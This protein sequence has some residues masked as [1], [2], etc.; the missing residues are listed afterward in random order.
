MHTDMQVEVHFA[1]DMLHRKMKFAA[2][3]SF[4]TFF[5]LLTTQFLFQIVILQ[6]QVYNFMW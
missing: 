1:Y 5:L 6:P 2:S 4:M 3:P